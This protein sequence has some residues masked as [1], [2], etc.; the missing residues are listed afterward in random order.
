MK[1]DSQNLIFWVGTFYV[2]D[3]LLLVFGAFLAWETRKVTIPALNDSKY[4]GK[5]LWNSSMYM[6]SL[7]IFIYIILQAYKNT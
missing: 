2:I 7:F 4:I 3:G 1:C 6:Q 5:I